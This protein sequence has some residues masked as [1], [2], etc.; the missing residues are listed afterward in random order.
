[1]AVVLK[2]IPFFP[3]PSITGEK[4]SRFPSQSAEMVSLL[5]TLPAGKCIEVTKTTEHP[6]DLERK[7]A[8]WITASRRAR[9]AVATKIVDNEVGDRV[10]RIWRRPE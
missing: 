6:K 5:K 3:T 8:H 2:D 10:L 7:R 1:M 9:I 4:R